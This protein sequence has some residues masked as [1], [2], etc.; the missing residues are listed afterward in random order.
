MRGAPAV[1]AI[2]VLFTAVGLLAVSGAWSTA[3]AQGSSEL[4]GAWI[5]TSRTSA[6]GE[7]NSSPQRG[8]YMFT[9][10]GHYSIMYVLG[11]EPRDEFSGDGPFGAPTDAEK[12]VAFDNFV[13]NSGRY[14][15]D[16]NEISYEAYMAKNP[17]YMAAFS[18]QERTNAQTMTFSIE[19][20][21]LTLR[22][23]S[24]NGVGGS[25]TLR[26]PGQPGS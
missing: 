1:A 24:G 13:A 17:N 26:R 21:I 9:E 7:A 23:T 22:P 20:G 6:D 11:D 4:A 3:E 5:V 8:L 12:L 15:V 25:T 18:V 16:G 14:S 2:L 19:D 10:S